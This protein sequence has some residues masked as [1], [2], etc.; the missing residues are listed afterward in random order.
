[1]LFIGRIF[2]ED[3]SKALNIESLSNLTFENINEEDFHALRLVR[4]ILKSKEQNLQVILNA[5]N[6]VAV[7]AFLDRRINFLDILVVVEEAIE[8]VSSSLNIRN[9]DKTIDLGYILDLDNLSRI[10]TEELINQRL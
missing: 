7:R 6:E 3:N 2:F 1:M 4:S 8:Y 5:A 9:F 10:K